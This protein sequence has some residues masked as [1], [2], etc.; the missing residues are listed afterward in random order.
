MKE[1][2]SLGGLL[3]GSERLQIEFFSPRRIPLLRIELLKRA[4]DLRRRRKCKHALVKSNREFDLAALL[5]CHSCKPCDPR[6]AL[7]VD[8]RI[9]HYAFKHR[10][11]FARV[12][13]A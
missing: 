6:D 5:P 1:A 3:R 7:V 9:P 8:G 10:R 13:R 12:F 11:A 4:Q 2:F